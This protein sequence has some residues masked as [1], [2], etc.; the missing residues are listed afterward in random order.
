MKHILWSF[1]VGAAL[2]GAARAQDTATV[3]IASPYTSFEELHGLTF[4]AG[5]FAGNRGDAGVGP[6]GAPAIGVSWY[7]HLGG[8]VRA[9]ARFTFAPSKR[10]V[11]DPQ[12]GLTPEQRDLGTVSSPLYMLDLGINLDI[13]GEKTW[14]HMVPTVGFAFGAAYDPQ[15]PDIG[16]YQFGTQF[17]LG[18]GAGLQYQIKERWVL[19][20]DI[21]D[22]LWQLHYPPSYFKTTG[23]IF[24]ANAPD[25]Q[26]T[27]NAVITVGI[28]YII[29]H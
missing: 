23:G 15:S 20:T 27:N 12:A 21:W 8:P 11:M 17:Y 6:Q 19:R 10:T 2:A 28:I 1:C 25:K 4:F 9:A 18:I 3:H 14:H 13:T 5:Y 24:P 16:G 29:P 26:W 22:Y 7:R